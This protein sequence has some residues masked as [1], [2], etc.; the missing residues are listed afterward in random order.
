MLKA[1]RALRELDLLQPDEVLALDNAY[2]FLR[3]VEHRLQIEAEQQTHTVPDELDPLTR[4]A[5]SLR[6]S[7]A[8][9][10][11]AALQNRMGSVRPIFERIISESPAQPARF[12]LESFKDAKR[13]EKALR[14]LERGATS[15]HALG[16]CSEGR[17]A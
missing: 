1:L 10:F 6:F 4:L 16:A 12:T 2:R 5:R 7:S 11:T 3:R 17:T 15:F 9:D 14:D 8:S 13:A